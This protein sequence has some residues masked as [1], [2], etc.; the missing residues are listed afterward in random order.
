MGIA[1][2]SEITKF[3]EKKKTAWS[4]VTI[5]NCSAFLNKYADKVA[6]G[7]AEELF[8]SLTEDKKGSYTIQTYFVHAANFYS[9]LFPT[10]PNPFSIYRKDNR[11]AFKN[12][13]DKKTLKVTYEEVREKLE[14]QIDSKEK[15]A[16]LYLL[17]SAQRASEAGLVRKQ[18]D[19]NLAPAEET[20][21]GKGGKP[22]PNFGADL[23]QPSGVSYYRVYVYLKQV[24][25]VSPHGLRKLSLT[26]AGSNG[27]GAAD[28]CEI[29]G[30]SSIQ[31][32]Y[33]Y[34]QPQ[35]VQALK[36]FLV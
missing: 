28:L 32:A 33:R 21:I 9:F 36:K 16:C 8:N 19:S 31:T 11:N 1:H 6:A 5:K 26:R 20:I 24:C 29:A 10:S 34:L 23:E 3:L 30:W 17:R 12:A 22:R 27:A 15:A 25:G 7:N 2:N 35:R 14:S 13:Y 4:I 18:C